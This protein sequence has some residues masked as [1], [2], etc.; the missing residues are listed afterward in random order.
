VARRFEESWLWLVAAAF[1]VVAI[2]IVVPRWNAEPP[3]VI[4][5]PSGETHSTM[6]VDVVQGRADV[7]VNGEHVGQTP[8]RLQ[9][10][11]GSTVDLELRQA[12]YQP[13]R[14]RVDITQ[15]RALTLR[16]ERQAEGAPPR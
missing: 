4:P 14:A 6:E 9:G 10:A 5:T 13:L 1:V 12:G 8:Y 2:A 16:M 15:Q 11:F 7:Y 3:P